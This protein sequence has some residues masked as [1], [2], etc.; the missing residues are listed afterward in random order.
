MA[1]SGARS[2]ERQQ[3]SR[4]GLKLIGSRVMSP[5]R[6]DQGYPAPAYADYLRVPIDP[7]AEILPDLFEVCKGV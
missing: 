3:D 6:C 2:G 1:A 7:S 5:T 4:R